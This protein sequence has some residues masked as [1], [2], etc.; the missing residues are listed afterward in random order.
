MSG[1]MDEGRRKVAMES[2]KA[3]CQ[4]YIDCDAAID[5]SMNDRERRHCERHRRKA[6]E[7]IIDCWERFPECYGDG[8]AG[9]VPDAKEILRI[10]E[11]QEAAIAWAAGVPSQVAWD[12]TL[13]EGRA[14][15]A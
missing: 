3:A 15:G 6:R 8:H 9:A 11:R 4:R 12:A 13:A 7:R 5:V 14:F 1:S 10:I 2:L